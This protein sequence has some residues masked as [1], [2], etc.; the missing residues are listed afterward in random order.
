MWQILKAEIIYN[1]IYLII[2]YSIAIPTLIGSK[3][4]GW[5]IYQIN[6]AQPQ[7]I[8]LTHQ[9]I[10]FSFIF[11][12]IMGVTTDRR[13]SKRT[14]FFAQLVLPVRKSGIIYIATPLLFWISLVFIY[15]MLYLMANSECVNPHFIWFTMTL[16]G[17]YCIVA[18]SVLF[19]DLNYCLK[20]K[21]Q[22]LIVNILGPIVFGGILFFYVFSMLPAVTN[23]KPLNIFMHS[24]SYSPLGSVILLFIGILMVA[25]GLVIFYHRKS[26][27]E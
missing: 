15:W 22:K 4:W 8:L 20:K 18:A 25:F 24:L 14:R 7:A 19:Y 10:F 5:N 21:N 3:L 26:Y 11:P 12:L 17:F 13:N 2:A 16:T 23:L 9:M 27:T 1:K 6:S